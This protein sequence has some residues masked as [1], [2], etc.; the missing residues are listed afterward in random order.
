MDPRITRQITL[1][2]PTFGLFMKMMCNS[3]TSAM[4]FAEVVLEDSHVLV[5]CVALALMEFAMELQPQT[6]ALAMVN[7]AVI[8]L[9][10]IV[11]TKL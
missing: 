3:I 5:H 4:L 8:S 9:V 7:A 10:T 11:L 6:T 2:A 1:V